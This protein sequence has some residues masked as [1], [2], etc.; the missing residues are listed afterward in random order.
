MQNSRSLA[1]A[2]A[3]L[4]KGEMKKF[5]GEDERCAIPFILVI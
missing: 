4:L 2:A 5:W 1:G 3:L